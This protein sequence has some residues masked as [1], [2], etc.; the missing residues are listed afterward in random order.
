LLFKFSHLA[1]RTLIGNLYI[2][3]Q[4]PNIIGSMSGHVEGSKAFNRYRDIS[5][6]IKKGIINQYIY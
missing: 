3:I 1:R 5:I 6:D 2:N 4:G